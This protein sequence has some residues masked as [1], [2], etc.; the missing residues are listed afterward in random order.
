MTLRADELGECCVICKD[1]Y[2]CI[3][4]PDP[5]RATAYFSRPLMPL[6]ALDRVSEEAAALTVHRM[7]TEGLPPR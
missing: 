6:S 4:H 3:A 5:E 1:C 2:R 7:Q